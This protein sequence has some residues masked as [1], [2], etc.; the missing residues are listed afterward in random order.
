VAYITAQNLKDAFGAYVIEQLADRD[1]DGDAVKMTAAID[2][3]IALAEAEINAYLAPVYPL[4]FATTPPIVARLA[5]DLARYQLS[6]VN[7]TDDVRARYKDAIALLEKFASGVADLDL[8]RESTN[9][10]VVAPPRVFG[11]TE[12]KG[13]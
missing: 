7:P 3:A 2:D 6:T 5:L 11:R 8:T 4:P 9:P 10:A 1:N 12:M 13:F